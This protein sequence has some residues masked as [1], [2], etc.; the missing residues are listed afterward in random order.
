[1]TIYRLALAATF[2]LCAAATSAHEYRLGDLVIDHPMAFETANTAMSGGGYLTIVNE[3]ETPDRLVAVR[4]DFPKVMLHGTEEKDGV[5][6]MFHVDG[7]DIPAGESVALEP[8][9]LHVMFM[10]LR[11][12]PFEVGETFSA[13]LVFEQA[14]EVDVVFNV[15]ARDGSHGAGMD[16]S[17]HDA[18]H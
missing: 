13:T 10:G 9:G 1:M 6:R 4:A 5:A 17:G 7:I 2:A 3:G 14:G 16:H 18:T 12:D 15:E 11:D 8:G